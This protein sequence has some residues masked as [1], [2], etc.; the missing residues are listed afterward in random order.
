[1][2][3]LEVLEG[4]KAEEI[5]QWFH[6]DVRKFV[7]SLHR[8][9]Y[10]GEEDKRKQRMEAVPALERQDSRN[11]KFQLSKRQR[12]GKEKAHLKALLSYI[13]ATITSDVKYEIAWEFIRGRRRQYFLRWREYHRTSDSKKSFFLTALQE[14]GFEM[15]PLDPA[16]LPDMTGRTPGTG[17]RRA[18]SDVPVP[19]LSPP[20]KRGTATP[21]DVSP[22][23]G[24]GSHP[25]RHARTSSIFQ[26]TKYQEAETSA[27][28]RSQV[29]TASE[30]QRYLGVEGLGG[31]AS[32]SADARSWK[33]RPYSQPV[34][35]R[36]GGT[37]EKRA[38]EAVP[39]HG[40]VFTR[41]SSRSM[42]RT[43][44]QEE[45]LSPDHHHHGE[46]SRP[47]KFTHSQPVSPHRSR[48]ASPSEMGTPTHVQSREKSREAPHFSTH[49]SD[50]EIMALIR[51][52]KRRMVEK[53][54]MR[55]PFLQRVLPRLQES[56]ERTEFN[57]MIR[58]GVGSPSLGGVD[59]GGLAHKPSQRSPHHH[60]GGGASLGAH[61]RSVST[62]SG[63]RN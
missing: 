31:G 54:C 43:I 13:P 39:S 42:F 8:L 55:V 41:S 35:P 56:K 50:E 20:R 25:M 60:R 36:S 40:R 18:L 16:G 44:I 58:G 53:A 7:R 5:D 10:Q 48:S 21:S 26:G 23:Q 45:R 63:K 14:E 34:S 52:A 37:L 59:G 33:A 27:P 32:P 3:S 30:S 51:E 62:M 15:V 61:S 28:G 6:D 1:M 22:K 49:F 4:V 12:E 19:I 57:M 47:V 29:R 17:G 2:A 9:Y 38:L 11:R 24:G 46:A